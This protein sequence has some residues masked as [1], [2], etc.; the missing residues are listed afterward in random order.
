MYTH[1]RF[2]QDEILGALN[3]LEKCGNYSLFERTV[4]V[5]DAQTKPVAYCFSEAAQSIGGNVFL[6]ETP[7]AKMHGEEPSVAAAEAILS[8]DLVLGLRNKSMAHTNARLAMTEN[9]GRYLSL[10]DYT[11]ELLTDPS[12]QVDFAA[13]F[14]NVLA[15][16][17]HSRGVKDQCC[18]A[19]WD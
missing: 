5:F 1:T 15:I 9:G 3:I 18:H 13:Q 14:E 6:V 17:T 11:L 7:I 19:S 4:I 12:L 8:A 2:T 10:P 16:G